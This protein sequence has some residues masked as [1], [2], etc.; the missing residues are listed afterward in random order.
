ML[1]TGFFQIYQLVKKKKKNLKFDEIFSVQISSG[2]YCKSFREHYDKETLKW[3]L[4]FN[5]D[6]FRGRS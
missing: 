3:A 6:Y 2:T 5:P 4:S 1:R